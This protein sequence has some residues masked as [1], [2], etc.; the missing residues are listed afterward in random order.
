M[1]SLCRP[2]HGRY[3][4]MLAPDLSVQYMEQPTGSAMMGVVAETPTGACLGGWQELAAQKGV[5]ACT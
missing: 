5:H 3:P 1:H 2:L 4:C